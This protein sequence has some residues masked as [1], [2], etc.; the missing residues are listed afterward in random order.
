MK[1]GFVKVAAASPVIKV[2]DA[3]YNAGLVT[4]CIRSASAQGVKVLV[5][6]ELTLTGCSCYD[7]FTHRV[8]LRGAEEALLT[9]L[10]ATRGADLLTFVG[11][12]LGVGAKVYNVAAVLYDGEILGLVPSEN[13][14]GMLCGRVPLQS[15]RHLGALRKLQGEEA[16]P[17]WP[18][19]LNM[20][21]FLFRGMD[22]QTPSLHK[23][24]QVF[25]SVNCLIIY[26]AVSL[27]GY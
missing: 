1:N 15:P 23:S 13:G 8:L 3:D 26:L 10:E 16:C 12:P 19:T 5:F 7:L 4:D 27:L 17:H 21:G 24:L 11:L 25:S 9:V 2:A 14:Y 20:A 18:H 6:P 22:G